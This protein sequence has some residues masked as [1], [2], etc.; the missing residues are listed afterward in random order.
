MAVPFFIPTGNVSST[1]SV[2][3]LALDIIC[4]L[5]FNHSSDVVVSHCGLNAIS[6]MT[7]DVFEHLFMCLSFVYFLFEM[8]FQFFI[9][10]F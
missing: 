9:A 1:C 2:F 6:V 5:N 3:W 8:S 10:H 7:N 4:L